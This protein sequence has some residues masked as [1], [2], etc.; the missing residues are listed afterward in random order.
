MNSAADPSAWRARR[1]TREAQKFAS[2]TLA[3][4]GLYVADSSSLDVGG[5]WTAYLQG[6]VLSS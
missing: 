4:D 2:L 6:P 1:I 3:R 5:E